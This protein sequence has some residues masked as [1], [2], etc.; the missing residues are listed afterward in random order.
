M[1]PIEK[2]AAHYTKDHISCYFNFLNMWQAGQWEKLVKMDLSNLKGHPAENELIMM[3]VSALFQEGFFE[4][5]KK[6]LSTID[7]PELVAG[8]LLSGA[9]NNIGK[10]KLVLKDKKSACLYFENSLAV[11]GLIESNDLSLQARF[12]EQA[13]ELEKYQFW[14]AVSSFKKKKKLFIDCGGYDGCSVIK[15]LMKNPD[16]DVISFEANP[17]LW[18]Y[19]DR[20]PNFLVKKA[21]YSHNGEMEFTVDPLDAD[22]S[23][24]IKEKVIDFSGKIKNSDCPKIKVSCVNLSEFVKE[25][26]SKYEHIELKLD[27]EG[28]EYAILEAMLKDDTL[29]Y[30]KR[31]YAEFHWSKIAFSHER[32]K[33]LLE[34]VTGI[35]PVEK[36]DAQEFGVYKR[37]RSAYKRRKF[38]EEVLETYEGV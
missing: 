25:Q 13:A 24:L 11:S 15:F 14:Y 27:V 8:V 19:H 17:E 16:F 26:F 22:G 33:E 38:F 28:A 37:D 7:E 6:I 36:W 30:V 9:Y 20:L 5:A 34:K 4:E 32:H 10:A 3:H 23:S 31:L 12:A 21:V 1:I 29:K 18:S 2:S 35:V